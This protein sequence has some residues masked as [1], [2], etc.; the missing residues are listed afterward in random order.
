[1]IYGLFS[2]LGVMAMAAD[3]VAQAPAAPGGIQ[4]WAMGLLLGAGGAAVGSLGAYVLQKWGIP[5][6][7]AE[8][9]KILA[10]ALHPET[11]D[12]R[13]NEILR[14]LGYYSVLLAEYVCPDRGK[15]QE[16]FAIA[17]AKLAK[18]RIPEKIRKI[19]I[20]EGVWTMDDRMKN[21]LANEK[22]P[23]VPPAGQ[24]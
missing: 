20:E 10:S 8:V 13:L 5:F 19:I 16:R 22:K 24:A 18:L 14:G 12:P 6:Y 11:A 4:G 7:S 17:D 23:D 3:A 9:D 1:M 2:L 15:G 21:A